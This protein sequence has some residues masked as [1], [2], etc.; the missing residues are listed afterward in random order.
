MASA[1][2]DRRLAS[3]VAHPSRRA[4]RVAAVCTLA[5]IGSLVGAANAQAKGRVNGPS[6][7]ATATSSTCTTIPGVTIDVG[8]KQLTAPSGSFRSTYHGDPVYGKGIQSLATIISVTNSSKATMSKVARA[9]DTNATLTICPKGTGTITCTT[10]HGQF[11]F[12]PG[13]LTTPQNETIYESLSISGCTTS[14]SATGAVRVLPHAASYN[15]WTATTSAL[16][17]SCTDLEIHTKYSDTSVPTSGNM[18]WNIPISPPSSF[19]FSGFQI[20]DPTGTVEFTFPNVGGSGSATGSYAGPA[21]ASF[22]SNPNFAHGSFAK[23]DSAP[24][25]RVMKVEGSVTTFG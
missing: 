19:T 22:T 5:L 13:L 23:C 9:S 16:Q 7:H 14:P 4:P 2:G 8:T 12:T 15:G 18:K 6:V 25:L 20:S 11:R 3:H 24:G 10:V 21:I 1:A 17:L